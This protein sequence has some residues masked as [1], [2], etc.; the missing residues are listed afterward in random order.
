MKK[1]IK[2][3]NKNRYRN[4]KIEIWEKDKKMINK[5][6]KKSCKASEK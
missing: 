1:V 2:S 6:K 4:K 5:P 3:E